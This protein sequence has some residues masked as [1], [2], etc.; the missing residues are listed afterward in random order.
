MALFGA[1][2]ITILIDDVHHYIKNMGNGQ[3]LLTAS[4]SRT[5]LHIPGTQTEQLSEY[6]VESDGEVYL[7]CGVGVGRVKDGQFKA[8]KKPRI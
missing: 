6:L 8:Y 2:Q 7:T 3:W 5:E 4:V 1:Q